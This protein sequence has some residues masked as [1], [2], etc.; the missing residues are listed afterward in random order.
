MGQDV[1]S[2]LGFSI[3]VMI[4]TMKGLEELWRDLEPGKEQDN[5][6]GAIV[7]ALIAYCNA[8]RGNESFKLDLGEACASTSKKVLITLRLPTASLPCL[9]GSKE[10]M[11][12]GIIF[13]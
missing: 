2:Q 1:C 6:L 4:I 8:L 3:Q 12:R 7:Y 13:C 9:V 5:V 10:K 11:E